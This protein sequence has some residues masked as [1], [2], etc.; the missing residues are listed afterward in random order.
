MLKSI[1][2]GSLLLSNVALACGGKACD[3]CDGPS[4]AA[5]TDISKAP[6]THVA[7]DVTGMTCG[8]CSAKV[9]TAL[10][11]IDGVNAVSVD[12]ET[13][14]AQIAF[15]ETKTASKDLIKAIEKLSFKASIAKDTKKEG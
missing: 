11:A 6:G 14:R 3:H 7:L 4:T 8:A 15:D 5:A 1:V 13:G 9:T 12:H 10:N 2:L